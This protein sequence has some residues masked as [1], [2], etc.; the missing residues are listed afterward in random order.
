MVAYS[1][2]I[3]FDSVPKETVQMGP[4][5]FDERSVVSGSQQPAASHLLLSFLLGELEDLYRG[6]FYGR[7]SSFFSSL[8]LLLF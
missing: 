7:S 4:I 6:T 5:Q 8:L 1:I 3:D 2:A